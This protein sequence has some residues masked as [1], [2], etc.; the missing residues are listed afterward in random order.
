MGGL[1]QPQAPKQI[2]LAVR[3]WK[4]TPAEGKAIV[5]CDDPAAEME[6]DGQVMHVA[7]KPAVGL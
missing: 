2:P 1:L 6:P 3:I 5:H 4:S 7:L